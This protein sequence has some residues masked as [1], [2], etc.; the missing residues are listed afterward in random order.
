MRETNNGTEEYNGLL[1]FR[2]GKI[3]IIAIGSY[4]KTPSYSSLLHSVI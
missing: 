3:E 2:L 4:I 1:T